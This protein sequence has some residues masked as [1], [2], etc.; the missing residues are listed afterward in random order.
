MKEKEK[1]AAAM[2]LKRQEEEELSKKLG[3]RILMMLT[4]L[5][6]QETPGEFS[7]SGMELGGA[8]VGILARQ[9]AYNKTLKNLHLSR[10]GIKDEE[11][12]EIVK[13]LY[14]NKSIIKMEFEGNNLGPK[15]AK[16]FGKALRVNKTLQYLDLESN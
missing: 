1:F 15:S 14:I 6:K 11:G 5:E 7:T 3:G 9:V 2:A 10:S 4:K 8:R 16:E 13:L 12:V